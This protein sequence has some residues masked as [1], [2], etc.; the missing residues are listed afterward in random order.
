MDGTIY[1]TFLDLEHQALL[2]RRKGGLQGGLSTERA[3][4]EFLC[5]GPGLSLFLG[6]A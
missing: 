3:I 4:P 5:A 2:K 6:F 1:E